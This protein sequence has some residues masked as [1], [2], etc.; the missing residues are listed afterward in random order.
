MIKISKIIVD[1]GIFKKKK[2]K[3]RQYTSLRNVSEQ[4][5]ITTNLRKADD[6]NQKF[7]VK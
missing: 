7:A 1:E 5:I 6:S 3:H 4:L 2:F